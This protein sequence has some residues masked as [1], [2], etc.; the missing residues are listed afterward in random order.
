[1]QDIYKLIDD[2]NVQKLDNLDTRVNDALSSTN[3]DALFILGETLFNFGLTPQAIEVFRTLYNKYPDESEL[4]IYLIDG[5]I[6]ED[7]TDEALEYLTEVE[8]SPEKLML[9]ADLYQQLNMLEV[10]IDKLTEARELQPND[11]I[12]HFAL[13]EIL[14]YDGQYLRATSE[15]ETVLETGE[16]EI[17][18]VNLFS[19][20]ADCSLQS[21]NY[22]DAIKMFDEI[23]DDEM[24]SEDY[25]K[26]AI[27]YDKNELTQEAIK[28]V[29]TLL[30]KDPDFLQG[31]FFLQQLH[32]QEHNF[33]DAIEIGKEGL[34]LSQFYKELMVTTGKLE[35]DHGDANEGV[36]LLTQALDVDNSYQEPLLILSDLFRSEE[37]YESLISLLQYVDEEDLDPVFMWHLA[38]AYGQ[39]ER[40]KEAQ[41]FFNLAYPTLQTQAEFLS[42][43]YYYLIEIGQIDT[44][45]TILNQLL[46]IEPSNET[47]H[48]EAQRIQ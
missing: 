21:G 6:A 44:A 39:E 15:Y 33:A 47:W 34:R 38:Y 40:D 2:I 42:D 17:N 1:M 48:E 16:Y 19:R 28:L 20:I 7:Q 41:H 35:I 11:P 23:S 25:F 22:S 12:I 14:Y 37:D 18:G 43:Y 30:S 13:A 4:L 8:V 29:Q 10:A 36:S 45:K 32:E 27:A 5:L 3:D 9:E 26:K 24:N 31:Y 46:E